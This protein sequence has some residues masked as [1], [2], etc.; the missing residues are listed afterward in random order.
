[1]CIYIYILYIYIHIHIHIHTYTTYIH[2]HTHIYIVN[3]L[4][5]GPKLSNYASNS[6]AIL[7]CVFGVSKLM[8]NHIKKGLFTMV[9]E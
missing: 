1:M 9:T 8:N 2:T 3:E 5:N 4:D 6:F 7:S